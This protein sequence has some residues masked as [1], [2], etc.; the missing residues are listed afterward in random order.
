MEK[1]HKKMRVLTTIFAV[2]TLLTP[3]WGRQKKHLVTRQVNTTVSLAAGEDLH[4]TDSLEAILEGST[5]SINHDN[6]W[7]FF[8]NIRP[9]EVL[10]QYAQRIR[11]NGQPLE[12]GTNGR[13][14]IFR[15]GT[16]VMA[17]NADYA[18]L[19]V[20]DGKHEA[21]FRCD[22]YYTNAAGA[23][24]P[25][26]RVR[27]LTLDNAITHIRLSRGYMATLACEPDGMG[28]SRVFV[29]DDDDI[30]TDLPI[31]LQGKV[32]FIRVFRWQYPSKKGWVG[33]TWSAMPDG[34]KYAFQQADKTRSTWYYNW[35]SSPTI[36]PLNAEAKNYNQ[37]FVP[38]KWGAGGLWDGVYKIQESTHLMGYNEPDHSEQ[39][40][41]TVEKAIEE[42]PLLMQ[43]GMRLGSPAT[44]NYDWLYNFMD[45]CKKLNYRV[46][47]VVV[48]AYWGG[49]SARQWYNDLK[50]IHERTG[51]PIWIKEWNN[52]ANWTKENW[53]S[54]QAEQYAKQ[55]RDLTAII[56]MLDTC[57]FIERYSIYNWVEDKRMIIDKNGDLTPAG[58]MYAEDKPAYFFNK[59]KEVVPTWTLYDAPVLRYDSINADNHVFLSWTDNNGEQVD[60][61]KVNINGLTLQDNVTKLMAKVSIAETEP[62]QGQIHFQVLPISIEDKQGKASN[63]VTLQ[64]ANP[65]ERGITVGETLV[66]QEWTPMLVQGDYKETPTVILGAPTYRNKMPL[67]PLVSN[68][69]PNH[70]DVGLRAWL[71]QQA[72]TFYA[73]DTLSYFILSRGSYRWGAIQA[74]AGG[75]DSVDNH[76]QKVRFAQ[77]FPTK[78]VVLASLSLPDDTTATVAVRKV[79]TEGFEVRLRFEGKVAPLSA[80]GQ[81]SFLAA[82]SGEGT[83]GGRRLVV[84]LTDDQAV[85]ANLTGEGNILYGKP[86]DEQPYFFAQMQTE[87]DTITATLRMKSRSKY[88][89]TLIKDREK[90]VAHENVT[91][92]QVGYM[93]IGKGEPTRVSTASTNIMADKSWYTLSGQMLPNRPQH[94]GLYLVLEDGKTSKIVLR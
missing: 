75:I 68:V 35:G 82:T 61:Y 86:F 92:E 64:I 94:P 73:P 71:Y 85:G 69:A 14:A 84:G 88:G 41:V 87:N 43:T 90:A 37:E 13:V 28:Y 9:S 45:K 83:I 3:C 62:E 51:R 70:F 26:D 65:T 53:P 76:W 32:S 54:S 11:I 16:A 52:G 72:P 55:L 91:G 33:S 80:A 48:H 4:V 1:S 93:A 20:T 78:P 30:D 44:T 77:V 23:H 10:S 50:T 22:Y 47:Y 19:T 25:Q 42:W 74:E 8:D 49:K 59:E 38:E 36:D 60:H 46:D 17:H 39:S 27:P 34:L 31:E 67:S 5:V 57:S 89:V 79:T 21:S 15:H 66:K 63:V 7:L 24:V 2:T 81:V 29:A 18:A 56:G 12:P 40:N 58:K 6:S